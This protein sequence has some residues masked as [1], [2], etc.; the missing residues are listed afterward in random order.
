MEGIKMIKENKLKRIFKEGGVAV[1]TFVKINDPSSIEALGYCGFDFV[2]VDGEHISFSKESLVDIIRAG[3]LNDLVTIVRVRENSAI[4]IL[5]SLDAGAMGVQ[6]PQVN[7]LENALEAVRSTKYNPRGNRGFA[8][9]H[10]A[11]G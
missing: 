11:A 8:P 2:V 9:S 3:E 1:G 7:T 4:E 6:V 5:Q 10:R